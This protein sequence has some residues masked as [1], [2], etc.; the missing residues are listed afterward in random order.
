MIEQNTDRMWWVIGAV[1]FGGTALTL[2]VAQ[3]TGL[4]DGVFDY[5]FSKLPQ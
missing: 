3:L 5:M 1:I 4:F 2:V